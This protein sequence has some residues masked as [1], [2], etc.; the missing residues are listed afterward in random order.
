MR[1]QIS[2]LVIITESAGVC[3]DLQG[4]SHWIT[5]WCGL[6][7]TLEMIQ[8]HWMARDPFPYPRLLQSRPTFPWTLPGMEPPSPAPPHPR[9]D[10]PAAFQGLRR[11]VSRS[12]PQIPAAG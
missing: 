10:D 4:K 2:A 3:T 8:C 9:G 12:I 7:R 5:A 11:P 6:E 1:L